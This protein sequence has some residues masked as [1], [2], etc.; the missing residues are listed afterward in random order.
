M[1]KKPSVS[2]FQDEWSSDE[3]YS[4]WIY[5]T[6]N[7]AE[8]RFFLYKKTFNIS[9]IGMFALTFHAAGKKHQNKIS[10]K[11]L[12]M[13]IRFFSSKGTNGSKN[14]S[15]TSK[16]VK[17]KATIESFTINENTLNAEIL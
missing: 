11:S 17:E 5:K 16:K 13:D 4:K 8:V 10:G 14:A 2:I 15:S 7:T 6:T 9:L 3:E 12:S 1:S